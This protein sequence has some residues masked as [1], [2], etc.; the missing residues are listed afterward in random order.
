MLAL[1]P[2]LAFGLELAPLAAHGIWGAQTGPN[3]GVRA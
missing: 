2:G 1:G 3:P